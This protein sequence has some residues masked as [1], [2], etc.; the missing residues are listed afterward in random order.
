LSEAAGAREVIVRFFHGRGGTISRGAGPTDRFLHA[1]PHG[2][3]DGDFRLTEQGETIAQKYANQITANYHLELLTA[4]VTATSLHHQQ[5][6]Q[7]DDS[8]APV[9]ERLAEQSRAAYRRL[10]ETPGFFT[11]FRQATPID[12]LERSGIGSRPPRRTGMATLEDLRAIPW[13]FSWS[14]SRFFLPGW[15]GVGSALEQLHRQA[16]ADF[17]RLQMSLND[18]PFVMYALTNVEAMLA[19]ASQEVM[20]CY[21]AC[22]ENAEVRDVV[23]GQVLAEW[24]RAHRWLER[25]FG[26]SI[27]SRRPRLVRSMQRRELPLRQ[28]HHRQIDLLKRW[29]T[30]GHTDDVLLR[31]LLLTINAI[32]SGLRTT[33]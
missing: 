29:R 18:W 1:L 2:T 24:D 3:L 32:A 31:D 8:Y 12:V 22:V 26:S 20:R 15:F 5:Q 23:M 7:P 17:A 16:P 13:V 25:A 33:G 14:Q 27:E 21:A 30:S 11:F 9:M 10:V 4:G 28:L 19:S 6:P